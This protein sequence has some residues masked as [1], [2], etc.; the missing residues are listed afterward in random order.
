MINGIDL[1]EGTGLFSAVLVSALMVFSRKGWHFVRHGATLAH[2]LG[3]AVFGLLTMAKVSGIRLSPDSSGNT[4]TVRTVRV[5][6][7]GA[8]IASFF[9]YPAPLLFGAT[10]IIVLLLGH[11]LGALAT[12][13]GAGVLTLIFIRNLFGFLITSTWIVSAGAVLFLIPWLAPWYVLWTG[14]L[15]I[16]AGWKD[17]WQLYGVYRYNSENSTDLHDLR[18]FSHI[19]PLFWYVLMVITAIPVSLA[20]IYIMLAGIK[21]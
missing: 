18:F 20:P 5:F 19:H 9:G 8:I 6:P 13:I 11:P 14:S 4:H 10:F 15:L 7:V 17:L 16:F 3:H 21:M 2:E 1:T 12:I